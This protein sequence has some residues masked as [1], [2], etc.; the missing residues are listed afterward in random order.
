MIPGN[1]ASD[2][3]IVSKLVEYDALEILIIF[4]DQPH[5]VECIAG[6]AILVQGVLAV[7]HA[8]QGM[9]PLLLLQHTE[10]TINTLLALP[11]ILKV[12]VSPLT[13]AVLLALLMVI[14]LV[15]MNAAP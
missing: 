1:T 15:V 11:A 3:K 2:L 12:L 5:V 9:L 4:K 6:S 7:T 10:I 13:L 8:R 14:A